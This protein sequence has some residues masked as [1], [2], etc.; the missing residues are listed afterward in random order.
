MNHQQEVHYYYNTSVL[1]AINNPYIRE[2]LS[3]VIWIYEHGFYPWEFGLEPGM[4]KNT[5]KT[6]AELREYLQNI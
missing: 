4:L 5:I 1:D 6:E 2:K 3:K